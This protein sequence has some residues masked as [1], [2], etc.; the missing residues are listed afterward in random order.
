ME[1]VHDASSKKAAAVMR[2]HITDV[3]TE[4]VRSLGGDPVTGGQYLC[5]EKTPLRLFGHE[6]RA[7]RLPKGCPAADMPLEQLVSSVEHIHANAKC[8]AD[9]NLPDPATH[10]TGYL[11]R[12]IALSRGDGASRA[13]CSSN[14]HIFLQCTHPLSFAWGAVV[15]P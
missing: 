9:G 14:L 4:V 8:D 6:L 12:V 1:D 10:T 5:P 11:A 3:T 7:V 13:P 15:R 2:K